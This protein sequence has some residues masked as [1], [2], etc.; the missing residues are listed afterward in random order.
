M[1][2]VDQV[3]AVNLRTA[4][5][6]DL[7]KLV[8]SQGK[9][10]PGMTRAA[11]VKAAAGIMASLPDSAKI[12]Q[13]DRVQVHRVRRAWYAVERKLGK[14]VNAGTPEYDTL[15]ASFSDFTDKGFKVAFDA[16]LAG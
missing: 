4:S 5:T 3:K 6:N 12:D 2:K 16:I 7:R 15:R 11:M 1:K 9:Y 14:E 8:K 10:L 13:P